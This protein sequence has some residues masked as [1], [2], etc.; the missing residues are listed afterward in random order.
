MSRAFVKESDR[1]E[2][3]P[4]PEPELPDGVPNRITP[5]GAARLRDALAAAVADRARA[6][7]V[8]GG[9]AAARLAD[10][11]V[12]WFERRIATLVET[13]TPA[14][15]ARVVFGAWVT[16]ARDDAERTIRVVGIDEVDAAAGWVSW[17]S[18]TR[19]KETWEVVAIGATR[20]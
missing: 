5:E 19:G 4:R 3:L 8:E 12:K 11:E 1:E 18:P 15:P 14:N 16:I 17:A 20:G 10:A 6:R 13:A 7:A 2:A 9:D